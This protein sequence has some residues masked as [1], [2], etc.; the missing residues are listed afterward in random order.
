MNFG[1]NVRRRFIILI[2]FIFICGCISADSDKT[3]VRINRNLFNWNMANPL[4]T[5]SGHFKIEIYTNES[6]ED[7]FENIFHMYVKDGDSAALN[8][9]KRKYDVYFLQIENRSE[10]TAE[11]NLSSIKIS[12]ECGGKFTSS[13]SLPNHINQVNPKGM[14][15]NIYNT[16]VSTAL[17]AGFAA[18]MYYLGGVPSVPGENNKKK[19]IPVKTLEPADKDKK[20]YWSSFF[21]NTRY[22]YNDLISERNLIAG[23]GRKAGIAFVEKNLSEKCKEG[24]HFSGF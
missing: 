10:E 15:K 17:I 6:R 14:T 5:E 13:W 24:M 1:K 22:H 12:G 8:Y 9:L 18:M 20:E 2:Y 4:K 3:D 19:D 23:K 7:L 11:F 16:I 21:H